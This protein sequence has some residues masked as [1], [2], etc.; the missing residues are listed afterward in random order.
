M[1][2]CNTDAA[3][4]IPEVDAPKSLIAFLNEDVASAATT[5]SF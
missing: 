1:Y 3:D 4:L 2:Y 5:L